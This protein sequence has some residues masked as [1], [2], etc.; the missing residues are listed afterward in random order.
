MR[1]KLLWDFEL[2]TDKLI[3]AGKLDLVIVKKKKKERKKER[4]CG[5][6][7][8][9]VLADHWVK[10][11]ENEKKYNVFARELKKAMDDEGNG[12]TNCNWLGLECFLCLIA[13]QP[14]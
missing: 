11:E 10:I 14:P 8:F 5:I 1:H 13:C 12:H 9:A 4:T 3:P 2:Q 7:G 6:F